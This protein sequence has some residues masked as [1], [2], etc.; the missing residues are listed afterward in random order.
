MNYEELDQDFINL[1]LKLLANDF[2]KSQIKENVYNYIFGNR[3]RN[4]RLES[5]IYQS[6]DLYSKILLIYDDQL[7]RKE[8]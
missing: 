4:Y 7:P 8:N 3:I 1:Q 5:L 6:M 2:E